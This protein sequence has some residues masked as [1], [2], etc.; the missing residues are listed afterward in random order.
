MDALCDCLS[1]SS[2]GP[3]LSRVS[4]AN[5]PLPTKVAT[6]RKQIQSAGAAL[7]SVMMVTV[8][9]LYTMFR[10]IEFMSV[11]TLLDSPKSCT[12]GE[13][14]CQGKTDFKLF[15]EQFSVDESRGL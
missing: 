8:T 4:H 1:F 5:R 13:C 7:A 12:D 10:L 9:V 3:D 14:E 15:A 11:H 6:V 2:R